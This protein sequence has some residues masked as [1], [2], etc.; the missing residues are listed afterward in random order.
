MIFWKTKSKTKKFINKLFR[1]KKK[2]IENNKTINLYTNGIIIMNIF[3]DKIWRIKKKN[4]SSERRSGETV[5]NSI[6][7]L[8]RG[9]KGFLSFYWK[10]AAVSAKEDCV[11]SSNLLSLY[12]HIYTHIYIYIYINNSEYLY[13]IPHKYIYI[14]IYL[15]EQKLK[16]KWKQK[17]HN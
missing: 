9:K 15:N 7:C 12:M 16:K 14:H 1:F 13:C 10:A 3:A 2:K 17:Q 5:C 8:T 11:P 6:Y 4:Y